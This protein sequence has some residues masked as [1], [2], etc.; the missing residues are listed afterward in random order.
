MEQTAADFPNKIS[1]EKL[2]VVEISVTVS[3]AVLLLY[4]VLITLLYAMQ[5][6]P[7]RAALQCTH[8]KI[9]YDVH[10]EEV[11]LFVKIKP[12]QLKNLRELRKIGT[13]LFLYHARH[14]VPRI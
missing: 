3:S 9:K 11:F 4:A 2:K 13:Q 12:V 6:V 5:P 10:A 7:S 14:A 8:I 1:K